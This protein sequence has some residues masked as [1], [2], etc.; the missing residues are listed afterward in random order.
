LG[1]FLSAFF[2]TKAGLFY[3]FGAKL[4]GLQLLG[5]LIIFVWVAFFVLITLLVL[6]GF[7][8]LRIDAETE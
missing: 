4:L 3:G 5:L 7:G 1:I 2:D 8:V 6:K